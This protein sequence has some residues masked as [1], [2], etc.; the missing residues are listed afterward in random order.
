MVRC[1]ARAVDQI[2]M[3]V[4]SRHHLDKQRRSFDVGS[5]DAGGRTD[6]H[7][8]YDVFHDRHE[9][10]EEM[11]IIDGELRVLGAYPVRNAFNVEFAKRFGYSHEWPEPRPGRALAKCGV[12]GGVVWISDAQ[13]ELRDFAAIL[14]NE[15]PVICLV[16]A[17]MIKTCGVEL[18]FQS[19]RA[20]KE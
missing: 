7:V 9:G 5:D 2:G 1:A 6:V 19:A 8:M 16:C 4:V 10:T 17:V 12:H 20:R 11:K 3:R 14:G 13:A 15:L 18:E